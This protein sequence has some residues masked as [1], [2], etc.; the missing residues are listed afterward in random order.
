MAATTRRPGRVQQ[1]AY[2]DTPLN[3]SRPDIDARVGWLLA[4]SRLHH[5]DDQFRD[6]RRFVEALKDSGFPTSRSLLS[7]WES[8]EIP[9]SYEGMIAYE[10]ALGLEPGTISSVTGYVRAAL[11]GLR[12]RVVRPKL[13]PSTREF[14][15]RFDE[16]LDLAED[17]E[18]RARDWQEL[19]W[20]LSAAPMVHLR[21]R[22]W[23][24]LAHRIVNELPRSVKV[25]YRQYNTTAM[26]MAVVMRAQDFMVDAI[27]D[28]IAD[29]DV[30]VVTN[31]MGLLDRLPTREAARLVL[32]VI[33]NPH[34]E[35]VFGVG[36]WCAAGKAANGDFTPEERS[37]LDMLV[38]KL[39]RQNPTKAGEDL[40]ELIANLPEGI[41]N[42]LVHAATQAGR[43]KLG[44]VVEHGEEMVA[45]K[46]RSISHGLAEG[47]RRRAPQPPAYDEDR[48]LGRLI[49]EALFHRDSERRHLA[50]L[51]IASS[52]FDEAVTDELLEVVGD[53]G[54][55]SWMRARAAT[56][57]RYLS[58]EVHRMRMLSLIDHPE[59]E[60]AVPIVQG[61]GHMAPTPLADQA[62]RNSL[63]KE[64]SLR[65]RA[66]VYALGMT[67]SEGLQAILR[68]N[69]A[70]DWQKSAARWWSSHGPAIR[71]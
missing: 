13:D 19:G 27:K 42:T 16:L 17:G 26:N 52:P 41:R 60:I 44:Y 45:H 71:G 25:A 29:P 6:G 68:S 36:V 39:W 59:D 58:T 57:V 7:R 61:L 53:A 23:R 4:M 46:A 8:G 11:P 69:D 40:A 22:T 51:L 33:T 64:W 38:L 15:E 48:M 70:P 35:A 67:G 12:T 31:P 18:A 32:D 14:A 43:R 62:L 2:D 37:E 66:K 9:I 54:H 1:I 50:A 30:Q 3:S 28:Y 10:Q 47:A 34:N 24:A 5:H 55:P 21:A 63:G 20:Y 56:L 49:R 65:E